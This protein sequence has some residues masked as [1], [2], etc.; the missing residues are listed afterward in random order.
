MKS[1][2]GSLLFIV[3]LTMISDDNFNHFLQRTV[4]L[5]FTLNDAE[6]QSASPSRT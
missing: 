3:V 6:L 1:L 5:Q 2:K 4:V